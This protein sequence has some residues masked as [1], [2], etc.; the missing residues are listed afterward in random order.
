M[1]E[2]QKTFRKYENLTHEEALQYLSEGTAV[3]LPEWGG[4]WFPIKGKI[5]VFTKEG[6]ILDTPDHATYDSKENW[7]VAINDEL[8]V[9]LPVKFVKALRRRIDTI[10]THVRNLS[11]NRELSL[12]ATSIQ[13]GFMWLGLY[14]AD[15]GAANPYPKSSDPSSPVIEKHADKAED[16][17]L[18][19]VL[20]GDKSPIPYVE[21][22][23]TLRKELQLAIDMIIFISNGRPVPQNA[24]AV[25]IDKLIEGKLWLGQELNNIRLNEER[26]ADSK[27]RKEDNLLVQAQEAYHRYGKVTDFKNFRGEDMPNFESLPETIKNAWIAAVDMPQYGS[28]SVYQGKPDGLPNGY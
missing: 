15:L 18:R 2:Q 6:E 24:Y 1:E 13:L 12:S 9:D 22:I 16:D 26:V 28:C 14:L 20:M 7:T 17:Y 25:A 11:G 10:L 8:T 19:S 3:K 23:K 21:I 27:K 4:I 5:F